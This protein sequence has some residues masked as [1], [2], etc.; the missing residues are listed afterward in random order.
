MSLSFDTTGLTRRWNLRELIRSGDVVII[1]ALI[2]VA[3]LVQ[4]A[5]TSTPLRALF[6]LPLLLFYPGYALLLFLFPRHHGDETPGRRYQE[7]LRYIERF[8]LSFGISLTLAPI[9]ALCYALADVPLTRSTVT[10]GF[11][12]LV[13]VLLA[14]GE[15]RRRR[16]P[17]PERFVVP[18]E[19][20]LDAA[21]VTV[22][23]GRYDADT[24][25]NVVLV[26]AVV[27][28][29][30]SLGYGLLVP[31]SGERYTNLYLVTENDDGALVAGGFPVNLSD[32]APGELIVGIDNH[33]GR[34]V[35]YHV[36]T[37]L[38]S[39]R[40]DG[41]DSGEVRVL[42]RQELQHRT[43]SVVHN[44]SSHAA[45]GVPTADT[46]ARAT[47]DAPTGTFLRL[48]YLLYLDEVPE[49]RT[50]ATAYRSVYLWVETGNGVPPSSPSQSL[51]ARSTTGV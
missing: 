34:T 17:D 14:A 12:S 48:T 30:S 39:V 32:D 28:A 24:L 38:Q 22:E 49:E 13:V 8:A 7:S 6:G 11:S 51:V 26:F 47:E 21:R 33:E 2:S 18:F 9:V 29:L 27:F 46:A 10:V 43:F 19:R 23:N 16:L 5:S 1:C 4:W 42:G 15:I 31:N 41:N 44:G 20:W 50:E 36:V 3:V 35:E 37:Q 25:L 45:F 40:L